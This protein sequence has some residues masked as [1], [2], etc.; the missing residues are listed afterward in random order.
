MGTKRVAL[1]VRD[2]RPNNLHGVVRCSAC[3][4]QWQVTTDDDVE[5]MLLL[6]FADGHQ[7]AA[8]G[9]DLQIGIV[10]NRTEEYFVTRT[11]R[12]VAPT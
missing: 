5:Q 2:L 12:T 7:P 6:H 1:L 9:A 4:K 3:R 8:T 10:G 11:R